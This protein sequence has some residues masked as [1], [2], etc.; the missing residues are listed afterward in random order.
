MLTYSSQIH[1]TSRPTIR[2]L[3]VVNRA[4]NQ[5]ALPFVYR[6]LTLDFTNV[7]PFSS[8]KEDPEPIT[9]TQE[10][11]QAL[12]NL[13]TTAYIFQAVRTLVI[14][15]SLAI[16]SDMVD[17]RN[18]DQPAPSDEQII[19]KWSPLAN[20]ISRL[21]HLREIAFDCAEQMPIILLE[22]LHIHH[23]LTR[24]HVRNWTRLR[25]DTKVG[26]PREEALAVS[27]CLRSISAHF[28]TGGPHLD[29]NQAA[30]KRIA[31]LSPNLESLE[32]STRSRGGCVI[33]GFSEEY[34][35]IKEEETAKF[36]VTDVAPKALKSLRWGSMYRW[37]IQQWE[38]FADLQTLQCLDGGTFDHQGLIYAM[39]KQVFKNLRK[40]SLCVP[41]RPHEDLGTALGDF[42]ATCHPLESLSIINYSMTIDIALICLHHGPFL[43]ALSLH[44]VEGREDVRRTLSPKEIKWLLRV[45]PQLESLEL[46]INRT[47][48]AKDEAKVYALLS[49]FENLS[50][51][52]IHY[53]L[54][55]LFPW[56]WDWRIYTIIGADFARGVWHAVESGK[57]E[58]QGGSKTRLKKLTLYVG[59]PNPEPQFGYPAPWVRGASS[60]RQK[61]YVTRNERDDMQDMVEV[62]LEGRE[63]MLQ[64]GVPKDDRYVPRSLSSPVLRSHY[65]TVGLTFRLR[66]VY[67][68]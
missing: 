21:T 8:V 13:E 60:R 50:S 67:S 3:L 34:A 4:L 1:D 25:T 19:S 16:W 9:A 14:H 59:E 6:E 46:D 52:T 58:K 55:I 22:A 24:L 68:Q 43:R 36:K 61:V 28:T 65:G 11:L 51:I 63:D 35:R 17:F 53:D 23:P 31:A 33:Y 18:P 30:L 62:R 40:L 12:L 37:N 29:F 32:C 64:D 38:T 42:L 2:S 54:G 27:Q 49:R 45:A 44:N 47:V 15:S 10:R 66:C 39:D 48:S 56:L 41:I 57:K 7:H 5:A 20:F 26:D